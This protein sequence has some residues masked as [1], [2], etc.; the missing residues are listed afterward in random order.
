[1]TVNLS[2]DSSAKGSSH[3][4]HS[5]LGGEGQSREL[6]VG[7]VLQ[8]QGLD[9]DEIFVAIGTD[10][11]IRGELNRGGGGHGHAVRNGLQ[12]SLLLS[13]TGV[14]TDLRIAEVSELV[15]LAAI[16]PGDR[17]FLTSSP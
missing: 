5:E 15:T 8:G 9:T 10:G 1:M 2:L 4:G 14:N 16:L 6:R 12:L 17:L 3:A 11:S 7:G 13:V